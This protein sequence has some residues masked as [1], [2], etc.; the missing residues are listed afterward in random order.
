MLKPALD[1]LAGQVVFRDT[2]SQY[3]A[4]LHYLQAATLWAFGPT[5]RVMRLSALAIYAVTAGVLVT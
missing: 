4:G 5:L 3:G 2:F 1:V